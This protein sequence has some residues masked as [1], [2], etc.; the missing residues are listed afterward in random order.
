MRYEAVHGTA[1]PTNEEMA[2]CQ[3][4]L[5]IALRALQGLFEERPDVLDEPDSTSRSLRLLLDG[6][7]ESPDPS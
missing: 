3:E 1:M 4:A 5:D 2:L 6:K 7:P